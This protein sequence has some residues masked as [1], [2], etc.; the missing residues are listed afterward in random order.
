MHSAD[1]IHPEWQELSVGDVVGSHPGRPGMRV[2]ILEPER[3]LANRS[4][5]ND[6][7]WTF[8][9]EPRDGSTRLISRN[10]IAMKGSTAG[11]RLGM[12]LIEPGSLIMGRKMVLGIKTRAER[13]AAQTAA[14]STNAGN[15]TR[16]N[17]PRPTARR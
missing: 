4:E 2:E 16:A 1:R 12:V 8:V 7:V 11:Q 15:G 6:R 13:L 3:V 9:L 5:A 14:D 10:R 17:G